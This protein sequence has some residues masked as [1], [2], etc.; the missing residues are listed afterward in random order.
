MQAKADLARLIV[1][2]F[3]SAADAARAEEEFNRVVRR[4]ES[5]A[6]IESVT[7]PKGE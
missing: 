6:D 5:S 7:F 1:T 2:D 3:H 4:N